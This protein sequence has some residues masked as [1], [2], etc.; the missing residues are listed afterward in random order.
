MY[1]LIL[2]LQPKNKIIKAAESPDNATKE[3]KAK[4]KVEPF[5]KAL[6]S[7]K[8]LSLEQKGKAIDA[9]NTYWENM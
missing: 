6:N 9:I 1:F 8:R 3:V 7:F 4:K 5:E 2:D